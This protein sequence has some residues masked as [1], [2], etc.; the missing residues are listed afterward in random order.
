MTPARPVKTIGES[1]G[2]HTLLAYVR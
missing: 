2:G 1:L